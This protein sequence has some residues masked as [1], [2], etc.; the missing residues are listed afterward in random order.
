MEKFRKFDSEE[1][2][3]WPPHAQAVDRNRNTH[4]N[5]LIR[6]F[7]LALFYYIIYCSSAGRDTYNE[8]PKKGQLKRGV[9]K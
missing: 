1:P 2:P 3:N 8:K 5:F 7:L 6:K 4:I 9:E